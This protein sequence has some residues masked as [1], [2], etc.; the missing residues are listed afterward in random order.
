MYITAQMIQPWFQNRPNLLY[1]VQSQDNVGNSSFRAAA[2]VVD[3]RDYEIIVEIRG[4]FKEYI[5]LA[6]KC[7]KIQAG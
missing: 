7:I 4:C 2:V 1:N 5:Y 3:W 6:A